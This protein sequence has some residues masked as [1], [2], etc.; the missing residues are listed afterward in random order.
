MLRLNY[1][2]SL[3][4]LLALLLALSAFAVAAHEDGYSPADNYRTWALDAYEAAGN[5][6]GMFNEAPM[7]AEMVAAG[8]P[9]AGRGPPARTR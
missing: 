5:S 6:I 4:L 8:G 1:R 7:L 2:L 3:S 9:A